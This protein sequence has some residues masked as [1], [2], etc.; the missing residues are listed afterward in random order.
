MIRIFLMF[1]LMFQVSFGDETGEYTVSGMVAKP[2]RLEWEKGV[3]LAGAIEKA[4]GITKGALVSCVTLIR[5][6]DLF[7][8]HL[9]NEAHRG[10]QIDAEDVIVVHWVSRIR[11]GQSLTIQVAGVSDAD[12]GRLDA[13]YSVDSKGMLTMWKIGSLKAEGKIKSDFA[14]EISEAYKKA[15]IFD[16][17]VF[18]IIS[19]DAHPIN[20]NQIMITIG[21]QVRSPGQKQWRKGM[22]LADALKAGGGK[23]P[24]AAIKRVKLYRNGKAYVYDLTRE[25]HG[26]LKIYPRDVIEVPEL[27]IT[28]R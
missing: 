1:C 9:E 25:K 15:G 8:Y 14:K 18:Q 27:N 13:T 17:A 3:T 16:T 24:Y 10:T 26:L 28:S 5:K 7:V 21:G 12:K 22:T 23:T 4:G 2:A 11:A 20:V 6:G 19:H